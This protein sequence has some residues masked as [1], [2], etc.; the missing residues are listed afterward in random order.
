VSLA[1]SYSDAHGLPVTEALPVTLPLPASGDRAFDAPS[2]ELAVSL[3]VLFSGLHDAV[4]LSESGDAA[5]A[6]A[7]GAR[8]LARAEADAAI[9]ELAEFDT[10]L[11]FARSLVALL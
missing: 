9:L 6:A 2:V 10:E 7:L 11:E 1:L 3:A 5:G 8:V 4:A